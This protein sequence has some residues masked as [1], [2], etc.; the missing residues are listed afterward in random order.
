MWHFDL[1][2]GWERQPFF[3][4]SVD[5]SEWQ[6]EL[7]KGWQK[8]QNGF[9]LFDSFGKVKRRT[10]HIYWVRFTKQEG[11]QQTK[12]KNVPNQK[13]MWKSHFQM[14]K[15]LENRRHSV[16]QMRHV[17]P[18]CP[19]CIS[20]YWSCEHSL[21]FNSTYIVWH[22][23]VRLVSTLSLWMDPKHKANKYICYTLHTKKV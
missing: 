13:F 12:K 3:F 2:H 11:K 17:L 18:L 10:K 14:D 9:V 4:A 16:K 8:G 15:Q 20:L 1:S 23:Y 19:P 6:E 21:V 5:E 22:F 7:L